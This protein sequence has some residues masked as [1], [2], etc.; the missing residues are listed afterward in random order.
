MKYDFETLQSRKGM[1]AGKWEVLEVGPFKDTDYIPF[2]VADMDLLT[3]PELVEAM[4][5]RAKFGMYGYTPA[6]DD[7]YEAVMNWMKTRHDWPVEK[8]WIL[9]LCG[10]VNGIY[11][12]VKA[13]TEPGDEIIIQP[14]VYFPFKAAVL[15]TGRTLIESPLKLNGE[16]YEMDYEDLQ[17]KAKTAK[18]I[19][20]C[21][22]H[23]PVGRVWT[24]EE[25]K[26]LGD[27]CA[28]NGVYVIIDEIHADLVN[29][30]VRHVAYGSLGEGYANNAVICT[31]ASKTF[32][33]PGLNT[34]SIIILSA[35]LRER[36]FAQVCRDGLHFQNTFG[37]LAT[38]VGYN[39]C[40]AW[41]DEL[42][43]HIAGNY[44][45]MKGYFAEKIP[46]IHVYPLEG[47][48]LAWL[49]FSCLGLAPQEQERFMV[50][51]CGVYTDEGYMFGPLGCGFERINL[52]CPR[53][54]LME[55]MER[56]Y[57][58]AKKKNLI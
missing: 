46:G 14:P 9:P 28:A 20:V 31:A 26:R 12:A 2:S 1:H 8:D 6:Q 58:A 36:F 49:D 56:I 39:R 45:A 15:D 47:T 29:P 53:K 5:E 32:S 23:N 25:L 24:A 42:N 41:V 21:S 40:G 4:V 48:Y 44:E 19:I 13:L 27:I 17:A 22:P 11:E 16:R 57:E 35:E 10:V 33:I 55:A 7:Y 18:A 51:D 30:S 37:T 50:D 54:P 3:P 43:E 34:S 38:I 52:A